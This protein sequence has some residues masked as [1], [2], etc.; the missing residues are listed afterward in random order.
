MKSRSTWSALAFALAISLAASFIFGLA[1]AWHVSRVDLAD[2]LRQGGKGSALGV[3]SG[4]ARKAF[5]VTEIALAVAL[6]MGA[7]LLGRSLIALANVD[8]GFQGDRL[9]VLRTTVPVSGRPQFARAI[10]IYRN[11]LTE[12]RNIPGVDRGGRRHVAADARAIEWRLLGRGRAGSGS[13]RHAVAAGPVQRGDAGIFP[14]AASARGA[15]PRFQ[16]RRSHR[17]ALRGDHQRAAREGC[18][19]GCRSD[20]PHHSRR[21]RFA[22]ADDHRRHRERRA[23]AGDPTGRCRR[24]CSFLTNSTR[25][26]PRRS[27]S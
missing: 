14:R 15:R 5:V 22:R 25:V 3:R 20:R 8:M 9:V 10:E 13:A 11:T 21:P 16:R 23:H 17:R 4:W 2:G 24:S 18:V 12:L 6:V 7:G 26:R 19:P 27:I 1:P